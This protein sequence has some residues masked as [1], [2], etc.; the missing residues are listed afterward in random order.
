MIIETRYYKDCSGW[1][2]LFYFKGM[3]N[4]L[5][6]LFMLREGD[7]CVL[8]FDTIEYEDF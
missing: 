4:F 1:D 5:C 8:I 3:I 2:S 7:T 6:F